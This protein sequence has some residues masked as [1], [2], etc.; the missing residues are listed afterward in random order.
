MHICVYGYDSVFVVMYVNVCVCVC[1]CVGATLCDN[2][3]LSRNVLLHHRKCHYLDSPIIAP[4]I[5]FIKCHPTK[6]CI[7]NTMCLLGCL[8][9]CKLIHI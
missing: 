4:I 3:C 9:C 6:Y 7:N 5:Q 8:L 2:V 1:V